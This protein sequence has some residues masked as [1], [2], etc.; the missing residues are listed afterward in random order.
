MKRRSISAAAL[1]RFNELFLV[2]IK[3]RNDYLVLSHLTYPQILLLQILFLFIVSAFL[4][5]KSKT[6]N[7]WT[8]R[9]ALEMVGIFR[10]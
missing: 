1:A 7:A 9:G 8:P 3:I 10:R 4:R 2:N 6:R 5:A